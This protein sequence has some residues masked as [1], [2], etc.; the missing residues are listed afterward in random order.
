MRELVL[1]AMGSG[2]LPELVSIAI[3]SGVSLTVTLATGSIFRPRTIGGLLTTFTFEPPETIGGTLDFT[4]LLC[5][6]E[7]R[8]FIELPEMIGGAVEVRVDG[9]GTE[10]TGTV[11]VGFDAVR[12]GG[13]IFAGFGGPSGFGAIVAGDIAAVFEAVL[14]SDFR[15]TDGN[16]M[17]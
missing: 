14:T 8:G 1:I 17:G 7:T 11:L 3:G 16:G 5:G 6:L 4:G 13:A 12:I 9:V 10:L 2:M 15:I